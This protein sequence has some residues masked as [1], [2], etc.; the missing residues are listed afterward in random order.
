MTKKTEVLCAGLSMVLIAFCGCKPQEL[1]RQVEKAEE[2]LEAAKNA[3]AAI[4]NPADYPDWEAELKGKIT[5]LQEDSTQRTNWQ[6]LNIVEAYKQRG[7]RN[8]KWDQGAIALME[9]WVPIMMASDFR[10]IHGMTELGQAAKALM[11]QGCDDPIVT[12]IRGRYLGFDP[13]LSKNQLAREWSRIGEGVM[14]SEYPPVRQFWPFLRAATYMVHEQPM[15]QAMVVEMYSRALACVGEMAQDPMTPEL[16]LYAA[17]SAWY[18]AHRQNSASYFLSWEEVDSAL[19]VRE[20]RSFARN[21]L[22]GQVYTDYAWEARGS[23]W[24][25]RVTQQGWEEFF[26]RLSEAEKALVLAWYQ[27]PDNWQPATY[28]ITVELG[29]GRGRERMEKW[30]QRAMANYPAN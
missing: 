10:P 13:K 12:Y 1:K 18:S 11:E 27:R 24:A 21:L 2:A 9:S 22:K 7:R 30:F 15:D 28:M 26:K 19:A 23:D 4:V 25:Y 14:A 3:D 16:D 5:A 20:D 17:A 29:Q 6:R 8:L